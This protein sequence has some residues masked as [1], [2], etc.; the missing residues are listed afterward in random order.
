[1]RYLVCLHQVAKYLFLGLAVIAIQLFASVFATIAQ[2]VVFPGV[3]GGGVGSI[4]E[5]LV[6][7]LSSK[8]VHVVNAFFMEVALT[9][10]LVYVIFAT[11]FDTGKLAKSLVSHF[12][13]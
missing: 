1:M 4:P 10:I 12:T 11:A 8:S 2:M 5:Y 13:V 7:T 3:A 9:F 6:V